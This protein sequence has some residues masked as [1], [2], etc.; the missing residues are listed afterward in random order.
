MT[1]DQHTNRP[2]VNLNDPYNPYEDKSL[3][4]MQP[5]P[6]EPDQREPFNDVVKYGDIVVGYERN[7]TLSDYPKRA[8]PW[9]RLYAIVVLVILAGGLVLEVVHLLH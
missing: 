5:E 6:P 7:R 4:E 8:R 3:R 9:V 1:D 2:S